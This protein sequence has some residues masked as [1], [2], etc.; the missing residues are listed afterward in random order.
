M[1]LHY[2]GLR[3]FGNDL[4]QVAIRPGN[5]AAFDNLFPPYDEIIKQ[6]EHLFLMPDPATPHIPN[7]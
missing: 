3:I 5:R 2:N 6:R 1:A 4:E 7:Y